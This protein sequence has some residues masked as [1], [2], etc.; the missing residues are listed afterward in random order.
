M[1]GHLRELIVDLDAI[2][3]NTRVLVERS[4]SQNVMAVV[5]ANAYGHGLVPSALAAL[6]G[7]AAWL[8]VALL[9]EALELRQAGVTAPLLAWLVGPG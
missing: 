4:A 5:K 1:S 8:G 3:A 7:G 2:T 6:R 9:D